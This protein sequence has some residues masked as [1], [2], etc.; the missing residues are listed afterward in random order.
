MIINL[1]HLLYK[2]SGQTGLKEDL[3]VGSETLK[4]PEDRE[5]HFKRKSRKD[6]V[7]RQQ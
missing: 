6:S 7:E 4:I 3:N 2:K 5:N 1:Y